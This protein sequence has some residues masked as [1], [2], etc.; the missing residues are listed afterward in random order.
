MDSAWRTGQESQNF[1]C[2]SYASLFSEKPVPGPVID[3][4]GR[5]LG[6]HTGIINYTVGQRKGLRIGAGEPLYVIDIKPESNTVVAGAKERLYTRE[7]YV[8]GLNWISVKTLERPMEVKARIRS[9]HQGYDAV[10]SP[11]ENNGVKV[12]YMDKQIGA[13]RGQAIV[14]Y[15]GD[16]VVGGGI[17]V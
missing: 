6:E 7:Q 17:A 3:E 16:T 12:I 13:A 4:N 10:V 8:T 9:S 2:G 1:V 15:A 11:S 14:F 5:V